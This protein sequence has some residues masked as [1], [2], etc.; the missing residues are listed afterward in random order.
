MLRISSIAAS[1]TARPSA[2]HCRT[3]ATAAM[4]WPGWQKPHC[5]TSRS[6]QAC[7]IGCSVSP[8][9]SPSIVVISSDSEMSPTVTEYGLK[10][11]PLMWDVQ[12]L[13]TLIPQPYLGPVIPSRSRITQSRRTSSSVSTETRS[14][15]SVKVWVGMACSSVGVLQA[16]GRRRGDRRHGG[17]WRERERVLVVDREVPRDRPGGPRLCACDRA[18]GRGEAELAGATWLVRRRVHDDDLH[19]GRSVPLPGVDVVVPAGL[20]EMPVDE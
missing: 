6:I 19:L 3:F 13:Q 9:A 17:P 7:C 15:L 20:D 10:A 4:I 14:P 5:G 2:T 16:V 11:L 1:S 12:A 8:S 18:A